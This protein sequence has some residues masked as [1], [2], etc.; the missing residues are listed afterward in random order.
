[1]ALIAQ[2][3]VRNEANRFLVRVLDDL[4]SYVD[5]IVVTDDCSTD[6]TFQICSDYTDFIYKTEENL[7][8]TNEGLLRQ[9]A[10]D[11]LANHAKTGDWILAIDADE[12]VWPTVLPI[13]ELIKTVKYDVFGLE[14][15]NMWSET[16]YRVDKF[17][18]PITCT[19][20]YRYM[21]GGK[22][23]DRLLACGS[24]PTYVE[25]SMRMG[26]WMKHS[27]LVLQHLGYVRDKDKKAKYSRYQEIDG[28]RYHSGEHLQSI[29]DQHVQLRE[30]DFVKV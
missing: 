3:V 9:V 26:R 14:F 20:L 24:E 10:L 8:V 27:G 18:A 5:E 11:N 19:K 7:F 28:G 16:H 4:L 29:L 23:K 13:K 12:I 15:V 25:E 17:W 22:I 2:M 21:K 1:M 30:W 6:D